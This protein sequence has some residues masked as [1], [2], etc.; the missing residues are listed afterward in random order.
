MRTYREPDDAI[1]FRQRKQF[2]DTPFPALPIKGVPFGHGAGDDEN[3]T[4]I[5]MH[6]RR[7]NRP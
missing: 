1:T 3:V 2:L 7:C 4:N 6:P 5:G